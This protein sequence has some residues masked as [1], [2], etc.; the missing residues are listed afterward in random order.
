[1]KLDRG[2]RRCN[3]RVLVGPK[4]RP[5]ATH[6]RHLAAV[7][8]HGMAAD[9]FLMAHRAAGH[10]GQNRRCREKQEQDRD[11]IGETTHTSNQ[12][13][14]SGRLDND[15]STTFSVQDP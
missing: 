9:A 6:L 1:M 4:L 2:S 7:A 14:S 11:D 13:I 15:S 12:S 5:A 10:A 8:V 3:L